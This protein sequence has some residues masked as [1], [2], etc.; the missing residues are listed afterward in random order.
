MLAYRE[1]YDDDESNEELGEYEEGLDDDYD[2]EEY[3]EEGHL[4]GEGVE[5]V[6]HSETDLIYLA[7]IV[8]QTV[9]NASRHAG[10]E[11]IHH[12]VRWTRI[13]LSHLL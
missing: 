6:A 7:A 3:D 13:T 5:G 2:D 10:T 8:F 12:L 11:T 9:P 4:M 1:Q